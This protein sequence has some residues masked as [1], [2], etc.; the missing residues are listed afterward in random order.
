MNLTSQILRAPA[1]EPADE[2]ADLQ[3]YHADRPIVKREIFRLARARAQLDRARAREETLLFTEYGYNPKSMVCRLHHTN[4]P[5]N[6]KLIL[7]IHRKDLVQPYN[8][9]PRLQSTS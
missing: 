5:L 1:D 2:P 4:V 8:M 7:S 6:P 3:A 9:R